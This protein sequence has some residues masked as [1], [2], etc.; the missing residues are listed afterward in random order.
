MATSR[1]SKNSLEPQYKSA[2][3]SEYLQLGTLHRLRKMRF[4]DRVLRQSYWA[5]KPRSLSI[6]IEIWD[7]MQSTRTCT[8]ALLRCHDFVSHR[9]FGDGL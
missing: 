3:Y 7:V 8:R 2:R 6:S 5:V 1:C 9:L 4:E